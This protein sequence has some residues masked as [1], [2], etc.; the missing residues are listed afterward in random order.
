MNKET[1]ASTYNY[2]FNDI[3]NKFGLIH[4]SPN[5]VKLKFD[6]GKELTFNIENHVSESK[7]V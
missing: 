3:N 7:K 2:E 4:D 1:K 6:Y 5:L